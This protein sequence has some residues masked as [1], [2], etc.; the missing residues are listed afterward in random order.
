[1]DTSAI[2]SNFQQA[3]VTQAASSAQGEVST[4]KNELGM[5]DFFKLLTTQLVNQD[6]LSPMQ[7]TEFISQMANFSSL[8]QMESI[9]DNMSDV[10][11]QQQSLV[12]MSLIGKE[13]VADIGQDSFIQGKVTHV[14]WEDGE[15]VPY[16]GDNRAPYTSIIRILDGPTFGETPVPPTREEEI[17]E[18]GAGGI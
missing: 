11:E 14:E 3:T 13:V 9:A 12:V 15:L 17:P 5:D 18:P 1:M 7:D 8:A 2:T 6:P 4:A 16:I 10:R